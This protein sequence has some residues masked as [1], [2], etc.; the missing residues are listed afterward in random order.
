MTVILIKSLDKTGQSIKLECAIVLCLDFV[1]FVG[2][3]V[4]K[5][6]AQTLPE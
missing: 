4:K 6:H 3:A 5:I 1:L 2:F